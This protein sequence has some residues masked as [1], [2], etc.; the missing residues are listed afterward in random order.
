[1][2]R[3]LYEQCVC[4]CVCVSLSVRACV[5]GLDIF[6]V[7]PLDWRLSPMITQQ[8]NKGCWKWLFASIGAMSTSN[9]PAR[10]WS[11]LSACVPRHNHY[12]QLTEDV[13]MS[14]VKLLSNTDSVVNRTHKA[15]SHSIT[16]LS[17]PGRYPCY[18]Y[19]IV[20]SLDIS[21]IMHREQNLYKFL[22]PGDWRTVLRTSSSVQEIERL[23][24]WT[25]CS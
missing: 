25:R 5:W 24:S 10:W 1:M 13:G 16:S 17:V 22:H 14:Y 2:H 21:T 23:A 4:V 7:G 11:R 6:V 9:C 18:H 8:T 19:T 15:N 12:R 3:T 20:C